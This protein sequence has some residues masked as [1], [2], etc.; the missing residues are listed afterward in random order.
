MAT[1]STQ[2]LYDSQETV[3]ELTWI[4]PGE[5]AEKSMQRVAELAPEAE[6]IVVNGM[7]NFRDADGLPQ[8]MVSL[9]DDLESQVERPIVSSDFALYWRV[10]K[11]LGVRPVETP[12]RLLSTLA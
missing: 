2:G 7:P 3:N 12:G 6:A 4:F 10:F 11:T 5:I 9:V 1:S 8:R